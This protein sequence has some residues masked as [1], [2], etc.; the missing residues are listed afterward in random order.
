MPIAQLVMVAS[1]LLGW[2][3]I[4]IQPSK[5]DRGFSSFQHSLAGIDRPSGRTYETLKR[6]DLDNRY[7]RDVKGTLLSLEKVARGRPSAELVYALA[8]LSWIDGCKQDRW[9]K[10]LALERYLDAV[11][12][13]HDYLFDPELADGRR[14]PTPGI[15]SP[16]RSTTR[17]SNGSFERR[18]RRTRSI[19]RGS[20][21]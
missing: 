4:S 2:S 3:D 10:A 14:R 16:A 6:Y 8:E 5:G 9:R 11:G 15:V 20:S 13:A 19:P 18:S 21:S 12:Y 7:R 17:G 1:A